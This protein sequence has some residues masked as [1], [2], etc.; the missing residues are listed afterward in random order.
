MRTQPVATLFCCLPPTI[1][2]N[3]AGGGLNAQTARIRGHKKGDQE[4][5]AAY[6]K[7]ERCPGGDKER[8]AF[9]RPLRVPPGVTV[10]A[11]PAR[12]GRANAL[13]SRSGLDRFRARGL[14]A[15]RENTTC[16]TCGGAGPARARAFW[17]GK[18]S[19]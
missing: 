10:H 12:D 16:M 18:R 9:S 8:P 5:V 19:S 13:A 6:T 1:A 3:N 15:V 11:A 14:N 4:S 7:L 2:M 17:V